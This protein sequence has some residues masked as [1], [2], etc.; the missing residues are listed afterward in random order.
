MLR[1]LELEESRNEKKKKWL[2]IY[3]RRP[4]TTQSADNTSRRLRHDIL[5][6]ILPVHYTLDT[7]IVVDNN[8]LFRG[9][10]MDVK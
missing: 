6:K 10:A 1:A 7:I 4:F 8:F 2:S 3:F 5:Y 9:K